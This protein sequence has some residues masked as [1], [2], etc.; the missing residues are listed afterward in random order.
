MREFLHHAGPP[1][2]EIASSFKTRA[3]VVVKMTCQFRPTQGLLP[4]VFVA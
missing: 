3:S 2:I 1:A 4:S